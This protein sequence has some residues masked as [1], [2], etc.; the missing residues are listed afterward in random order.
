MEQASFR[1]AP[2]TTLVSSSFWMCLG[3]K[4]LTELKLDDKEL[5][6]WGTFEAGTPN[7]TLRFHITEACLQDS[8]KSSSSKYGCH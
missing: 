5:L 8:F 7:R 1:F 6:I 4:K 3:R 2:F